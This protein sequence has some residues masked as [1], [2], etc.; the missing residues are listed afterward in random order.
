MSATLDALWDALTE[1]LDDN[2]SRGGWVGSIIR[3]HRPAI[4]AATLSLQPDGLDAALAEAAS[5]LP[6]G[7]HLMGLVGPMSVRGGGEWTASAYGMVP[8]NHAYA[9]GPTPAAAFRALVA[10]L[11]PIE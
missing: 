1:A 5:A 11:T 6:K 2:M 8:E 3:T 7:W 9:D 10:R 4:E